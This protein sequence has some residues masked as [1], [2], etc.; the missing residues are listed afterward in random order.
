MYEKEL[1]ERNKVLN[2]YVA[3]KMAE[4]T[5]GQNGLVIIDSSI[6]RRY[7][8]MKEFADKYEF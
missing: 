8:D 4:F 5:K 6:D 3:K 2:E 7:E 1:K